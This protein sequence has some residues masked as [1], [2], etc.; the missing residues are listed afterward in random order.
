MYM[1]T[2]NGLCSRLMSFYRD[3]CVVGAEVTRCIGLSMLMCMSYR[4]GR[5]Y[6]GRRDWDAGGGPW[7]GPG[8]SP[9]KKRSGWD[10]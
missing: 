8:M 6:R 4:R 10:L 1:V 9:Q 5:V 2:S 3:M 7:E